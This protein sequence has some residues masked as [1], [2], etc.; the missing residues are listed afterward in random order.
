MSR[1]AADR[2]MPGQPPVAGRGARAVAALLRGYKRW[3][4]PL[5]PRACRYAPTCSEYARL[6]ILRHGVLRGS[7]RALWRLMRCQPLGAGGV[8]LP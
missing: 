5:L 6:A 2:P 7:A 1:T 3:I 4:S 8:D